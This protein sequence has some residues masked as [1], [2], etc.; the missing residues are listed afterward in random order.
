[1]TAEARLDLAPVPS[2]DR[3]P[4][5]DGSLVDCREKLRQLRENHGEL[6]AAANHTLPKLIVRKKAFGQQHK[7][8]RKPRVMRH[9]D[10]PPFLN[11]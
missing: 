1:M 8:Y 9:F 5:P 10:H 3:W 11:R 2:A 4:R 7:P 6:E